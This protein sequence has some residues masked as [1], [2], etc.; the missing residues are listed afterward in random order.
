MLMIF[1]INS[2]KQPRKNR[3]AGRQFYFKIIHTNQMYVS[4]LRMEVSVYDTC[5]QYF[6][7]H[8]SKG[9]SICSELG[10]LFLSA[11]LYK[12]GHRTVSRWIALLSICALAAEFI[13]AIVL[14][15]EK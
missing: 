2:L 15:R 12:K 11:R 13:L 1:L 6:L 8:C 9:V 7:M 10:L 4:I 5:T 14:R 3:I